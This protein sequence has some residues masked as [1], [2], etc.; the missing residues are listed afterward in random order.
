MADTD[1]FRAYLAIDKHALDQELQEQPMLFF[2]ISEAFVQAAAERDML[3]EQLA[4][5]DARLDGEAR[6]ILDKSGDKYTE[7]MVKNAV[8][9]DKKH[10]AGMKNYLAAKEQADVL[11]AL[12]EAF[13]SRGYM[14]KDLC[15]LYVSNYY[16]EE[17][18]KDT[19]TTDFE[20][21]KNRD[22]I[23]RAREAKKPTDRT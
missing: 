9:T 17:S 11:A 15:N 23:S 21:R 10:E 14:L 6:R 16:D 22:H 18:F 13:H 1:E 20:Y 3:K 19:R 12:K 4:T 5:V 7:A 8:Q 2:K